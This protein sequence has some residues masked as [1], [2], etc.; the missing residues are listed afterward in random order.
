MYAFAYMIQR[1]RGQHLYEKHIIAKVVVSLL[2]VL[3]FKSLILFAISL[4]KAGEET[5]CY[6]CY[7]PQR[8]QPSNH[9]MDSA[10]LNTS[11]NNPENRKCNYGDIYQ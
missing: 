7:P 8:P 1:H 11:R 6:H 2:M 5:R 10:S 9:V 4:S 3:L